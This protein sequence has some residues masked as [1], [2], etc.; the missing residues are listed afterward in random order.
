MALSRSPS[1]GA[2]QDPISDQQQFEAEEEALETHFRRQS[3]DL[4]RENS[5]F[6]LPEGRESRESLS[7]DAAVDPVS[8]WHEDGEES[9]SVLYLVLLTL[10]IGG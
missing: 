10:S 8:E 2:S 4:D 3:P 1:P 6:I 9:K 7:Q 5:P